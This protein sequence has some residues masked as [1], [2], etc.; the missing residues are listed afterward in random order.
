MP[1]LAVPARGWI[2]GLARRATYTAGL[3]GGLVAA[4]AHSA[5]PLLGHPRRSRFLRLQE[6]EGEDLTRRAGGFIQFRS[7]IL[8]C[9]KQ[10]V[11][12]ILG[13]PRVTALCQNDL[14]MM[15]SQRVAYTALDEWYYVFDVH[16]HA[17]VVVRFNLGRVRRVEF[18]GAVDN[19]Q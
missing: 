15:T 19:G 9:T 16:R 13:P 5:V 1:F 10:Q 18:V 4:V 8:G 17:A 6:S 11:C 7:A 3:F 12:A 14:S 2:H